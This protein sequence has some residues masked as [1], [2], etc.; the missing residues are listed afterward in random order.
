MPLP[1]ELRKGMD[2]QIADIANMGE[3][4]GRRCWSPACSCKEFVGEGIPWAH[5][6]IA[7][8]GLQ[9]GRA[10]RLHPQGRYGHGGPYAGPVRGADRRGDLG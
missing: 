7:G 9:R 6:D 4:D 10:V 1:D 2:S 8:P 5:L 3:R